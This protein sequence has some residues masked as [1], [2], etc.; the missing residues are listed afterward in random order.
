MR[1]TTVYLGLGGNIG[2]TQAVFA[3]ALEQLA[4]TPGITHLR[5][6]P[7][8]VTAPHNAPPQPDFINAVCTF[9]TTLPIPELIAVTQTIERKLGKQPKPKNQPRILDI[10]ILL[11]GSEHYQTADWQIPHAHWRERPFV[12]VPLQDLVSEVFIPER[13]VIADLL[14][15]LNIRKP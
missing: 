6:S 5:L 4:A 15:S 14:A 12:L 7:L 2:D 13:V 1:K 10:D 8:Y 3:R 9:E 11:F